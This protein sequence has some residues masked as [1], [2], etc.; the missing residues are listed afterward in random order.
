M[1]RS[2]RRVL[3]TARLSEVAAPRFLMFVVPHGD[4][5]GWQSLERWSGHAK[6][7]SDSTAR[8]TPWTRTTCPWLASL[9]MAEARRS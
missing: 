7:T 6:S 3:W 4:S 1:S 8:T 5:R 9:L 2:L